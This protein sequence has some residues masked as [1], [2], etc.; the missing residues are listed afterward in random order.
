MSDSNV[1]RRKH[2]DFGWNFPQIDKNSIRTIHNPM[3]TDTIDENEINNCVFVENFRSL[4]SMSPSLEIEYSIA[5]NKIRVNTEK[6]HF[7]CSK[8]L[9]LCFFLIFLPLLFFCNYEMTLDPFCKNAVCVLSGPKRVLF[10]Q[11]SWLY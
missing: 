2:N 6:N 8:L 5:N 4:E 1:N 3:K 11:L 7:F 9:T 10:I